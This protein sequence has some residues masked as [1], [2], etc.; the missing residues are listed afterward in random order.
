MED[1]KELIWCHKYTIET[2]GT[3]NLETTFKLWRHRNPKTKRN[4]NEN[5]LATQKR[6]IE[7]QKKAVNRRD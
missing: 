6:Y 1:Y 7:N 4:L 2:T 3:A 5:T